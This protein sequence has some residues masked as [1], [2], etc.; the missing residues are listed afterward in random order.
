[1]IELLLRSGLLRKP[2]PQGF[3]RRVLGA[4]LQKDGD[5]GIVPAGVR[6]NQMNHHLKVL[7]ADGLFA[8]MVEVKLPQLIA[9]AS[10]GDKAARGV[11][12][13]HRMPVV[14]DAQGSGMVIELDGGQVGLFRIA[15]VNRRL[16]L[17]NLASGV[18]PLQ[19]TP[20]LGALLPAVAPMMGRFLLRGA[21]SGSRSEHRCSQGKIKQ[22]SS[23]R[24]VHP[25][26]CCMQ[27]AM[28][29]AA[30][31]CSSPD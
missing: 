19:V 29:P 13:L 12:H 20:V 5:G 27:S 18:L 22:E 26:R 4:N 17:S 28:E 23:M 2:A 30:R 16:M 9:L 10:H 7:A 3:D 6:M 24:H 31:A 21:Y 14:D 25:P 8:G 1:V 11:V 15:N